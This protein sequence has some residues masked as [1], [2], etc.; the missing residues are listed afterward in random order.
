MNAEALHPPAL[1]FNPDILRWAREWRGRSV[2]EAAHKA[3]VSEEKVYA[4]ERGEAI[5][6]VRQGRNLANFYDRP[7]LD[8]F[9]SR[10][11]NVAESD[12]VPDFRLHRDHADPRGDRELKAIQAWAEDIRLNALD[13]FSINGEHPPSL[14]HG[15][16]ATLETNPELAA[17]DARKHGPFSVD[18]QIALKGAE[19]GKVAKMLR[20]SI[21]S[22][23]VLVLKESGV[24]RYGVRGM[25]VFATP[26]PIVIFGS[27]AP[28]AQAFTMAHE[29][30]H[31]MLQQSAISGPPSASGDRTEIERAERWCDEFAGAFL[32]P[33]SAMSKVWAKPNAPMAQIGDGLLGQLANTFSVSRHAMLIRLVHL[34]YV[35]PEFYW[36]V[37]RPEFLKDEAAFKGGGRPLYYG[38]RFRSAVGDMYTGLVLTAWG[39]GSITNHNAAELM[40]TKSLQHLFDIRDHFTS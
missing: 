13:L 4:W 21:E 19:R 30:G 17:V 1:P 31:I 6:T 29:L 18:D 22:M 37:K 16:H 28:T 20:R 12:L 15:F 8:F 11:P 32:V 5:P 35:D 26:L 14:P 36:S 33:A 3:G 40:G 2:A 34:G 7:F 38:S 23:G 27:E 39:N 24:S 10:R 9:L 25:T